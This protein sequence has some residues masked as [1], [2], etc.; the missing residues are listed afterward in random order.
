MK[1]KLAAQFLILIL[2]STYTRGQDSKWSV[3]IQAGR[4][5]L[6]GYNGLSFDHLE[7]FEAQ[8]MGGV[9]IQVYGRFNFYKRA[10]VFASGGINNLVSGMR[11]QGERGKNFGT[12]GVTPQYF[13]GIDYDIPFGKS[14]YGII[15]KLAYG[16]TGSN[17][18]DKNLVRYTMEEEGFPAIG[19]IVVHPLTGERQDLLVYFK[20]VQLFASEYKFIYHFRPE[21]SLYKKYDRHQFSLSVVYAFAPNRDFYTEN[22]YDLEFKGNR[23]TA[24]HHFGG[25]YTAL[26]FGY[27]FRFGSKRK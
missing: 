20:D 13:V 2:L 6:V 9:N 18:R 14:G 21:L 24:Y 22:F 5:Q 16:I 1:E 7:S 19:T 23:H 25:H 27:E 15:S 17:A 12:S 26:L 3:G 4:T 10:S 11:F 8:G